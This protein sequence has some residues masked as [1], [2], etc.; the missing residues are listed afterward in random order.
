METLAPQLGLPVVE[1]HQRAEDLYAADALFLT[2]SVMG[3]RAISRLD[4]KT[5]ALSQCLLDLQA[6][7]AREARECCE[8]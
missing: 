1:Q 7:Y 5:F 8:S 2:N 3:L 6:A 4:G